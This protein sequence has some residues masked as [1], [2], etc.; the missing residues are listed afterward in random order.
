MSGLYAGFH[1]VNITPRLGIP[2]AGYYQTRIS[3]GVLDELETSAVA[4]KSGENTALIIS[5]DHLGLEQK[6]VD[7]MRKRVSDAAGVP[8]DGIFIACTHTHTAPL[9]RQADT[10]DMQREYIDFLTNRLA[11]AAK[12]A[13][14][15]LKP[16]K[17]G[18]GRAHAPNIAFN[19]RYYMKNGEIRT[20]PGV[21][22][23]DVASAVGTADDIVSVLR[24]DRE[25]GETI[26][27]AHFAVHPDTVGGANISA[28]WPGFARRFT[29]SAIENTRCIVL[30]G[31][32]G[33]INHVNVSP[34]AG[35]ENDLAPDFDDCP[36][37]YG[38]ARHMG[39]CVAGTV[40]QVFDK[41]EYSFNDDLNVRQAVIS[42]KSN[43]PDIGEIDSARR[44]ND[45]HKAGRDS[46]IPYT[47]MMLTTVVAEAE[48]M[49]LLE[50]GPDEFKV[51]L[52][53]VSI[54]NV[55]LFGVAGEPFSAIGS[56]MKR[57]TGNDYTL[58]CCC[59]NGNEGYFP[60]LDAYR[61]G[62]YESRS[63]IFKAGVAEA[64]INEGTKLLNAKG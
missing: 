33:D 37:G 3:A 16:A 62:G 47:G 6:W 22:N 29:E 32:Q 2:L 8:L 46:E 49:L 39:R 24:F 19:R 36:R 41:V 56:A 45:L 21:N 12:M 9:I 23:P 48:R 34:K 31:A 15:D 59:V 53:C 28:D 20:N 61:D 1:R 54:G 17:M 18:R 26:L 55:N 44:I 5:V 43:K 25:T 58:T 4:L 57:E 10:D 63:S 35:D 27:I 14:A 13:V 30:N 51:R 60:T 11:D 50:N 42:V 38:H 52:S 7:G 64:I 40:M